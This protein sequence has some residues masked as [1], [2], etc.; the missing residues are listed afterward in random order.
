VFRSERG[1]PDPWD[2][3]NMNGKEMPMDS[4]YYIIDPGDGSDQIEG[5]V[6][7]IR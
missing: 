7:I 2:G 4:Y 6:T 5:T 1:Y 3:R